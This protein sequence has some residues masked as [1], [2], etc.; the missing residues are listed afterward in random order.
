LFRVVVAG[1][2]LTITK[3]K[4]KK[5]PR[6]KPLPLGKAE[7]KFET[8]RWYTLQIEIV[9]DRVAVETDNGV[10][11]DVRHPGLDVEKTGYRFVMR[12]STLYV[13][14]V[15]VWEVRP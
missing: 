11:L 1:S 15:S 4:D 10:K 2:G 3:D 9:G 6:S 14:D 5:D 8:G 7:G 12:G 13:D